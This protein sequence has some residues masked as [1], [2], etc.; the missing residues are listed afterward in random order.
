M[1]GTLWSLPCSDWEASDLDLVRGGEMRARARANAHVPLASRF[2]R[3]SLVRLYFSSSLAEVS[4]YT[5]AVY[6]LSF[7]LCFTVTSPSFPLKTN[8]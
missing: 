2:L 8:L 5:Q 4:Y 7:L 1:Y 6:R 3:V